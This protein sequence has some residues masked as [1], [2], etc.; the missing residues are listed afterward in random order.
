MANKPKK[1]VMFIVEGTTD[2]DALSQILQKIFENEQVRFHIVFGDITTD[3]NVDEKHIVN[4]VYDHI[5][6]EMIK[7][8]ISRTNIIKIIHLIDT[9][10]A[11]IPNSNVALGGNVQL[12]YT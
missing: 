1:I 12:I 2:E 7:Y 3:Y 5:K 9:D 11:F 6:S 8:K 4:E 10:G